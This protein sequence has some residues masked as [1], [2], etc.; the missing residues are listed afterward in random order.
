MKYYGTVN[1]E[2]Y[3]EP[4]CLLNMHPEL[5]SIPLGRVIE[6]LDSFLNKNDY[7]GAE[8]LLKNWLSEAESLGDEKGRLS[9][10]NEQIGLYRKLGRKEDCLKAINDAMEQARKAGFEDSIT[11]AT[12]CINA[13]TG[14]K[15]FDKAKEALPLYQRAKDLYEKY[16]DPGDKRM[17][18]LYNN[19]A[20]TLAGL[21]KYDE[22]MA[23]YRA[24]LKILEGKSEDQPQKNDFFGGDLHCSE[25]P[26]GFGGQAADM[27]VTYLNMADLLCARYGPEEAEKQ[28]EEYLNL[29]EELLDS[30]GAAHD[31]YY[32]YVCEKCAPVFGYYGYF[33]TEQ[34]LK[35]RAE[36]I[37]EGS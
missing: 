35:K 30:E 36:E 6:K 1:K 37:Y 9:L 11:G 33:L 23:L 7:E 8:A 34:K 28:V 14:Y 12:T 17:A 13:A 31:G 4:R 5:V 18:G 27:A 25:P 26:A 20:L 32:A 24:A 16:L 22:A 3:E 19:M 15:A 29:A 10:L 2:D 21:E